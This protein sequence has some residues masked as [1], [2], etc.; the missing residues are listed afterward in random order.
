[1]TRNRTATATRNTS[2][3]QVTV[4]V[5]LDGTGAH[6]IDTG[7]PFYDH[8]LTALARH[9]LIDLEIK[10]VGDTHIERSSRR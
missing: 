6:N 2:E 1:M 4:T 8:M 3:S 5:D 7:V 10:A 9:S